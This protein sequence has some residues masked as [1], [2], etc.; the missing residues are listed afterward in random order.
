MDQIY[1]VLYGAL[2]VTLQNSNKQRVGDVVRGGNVL[3]EEAFFTP[4]PVYKE[5]A[6]GHTEEVGLLAVDAVL[7]SELGT[8]N[9]QGKGQNMLAYQRDFKA[10][11]Q[12][13][14]EIHATKEAWRS[15]ALSL[16]A[17]QEQQRQENNAPLG[18]N[19]LLGD[20]FTEYRHKSHAKASG[21]YNNR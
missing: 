13:L 17:K 8:N 18:S 19:Q 12:L 14:K 1:F 5:T 3:G 4:K 20:G 7:L 15:R 21:K 6:V 16:L 10:L 11:F 2:M 9:F